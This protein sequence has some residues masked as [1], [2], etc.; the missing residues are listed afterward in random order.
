LINTGIKTIANDNKHASIIIVSP[1]T[2]FHTSVFVFPTPLALRVFVRGSD[3]FVSDS[4]SNKFIECW[5]R[6]T[7][8]RTFFEIMNHTR[9]TPHQ[10]YS[11][12]MRF[13]GENQRLKFLPAHSQNFNPY[14][15]ESR[16]SVQMRKLAEM[17]LLGMLSQIKS[18]NCRR[19][20]SLKLRNIKKGS[21]KP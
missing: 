9:L 7:H 14:P 6:D 2:K 13:A 20:C 8:F 17:Q 5:H 4:G 3:K 21:Y 15:H 18:E 19:H 11:G 10:A 1:P 16:Y 12:G